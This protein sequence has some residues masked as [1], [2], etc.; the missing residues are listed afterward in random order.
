MNLYCPSCGAEYRPGFTR[1][2]DCGIELADTPPDPNKPSAPKGSTPL[3]HRR[4]LVEVYQSG[5]MDAHFV[6][7]MLESNGIATV[8]KEGGS[9]MYPVNVGG[10]S[11][12]RVLVVR[13]DAP[14]ARELIELSTRESDDGEEAEDDYEDYETAYRE[15]WYRSPAGMAAVAL[16]LAALLF[17]AYTAG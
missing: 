5:P 12:S 11:D 13:E 3:E 4:D 9:G 8:F 17:F 14:V 16:F 7:S 2:S 15:P 1:C 10:M 6:R